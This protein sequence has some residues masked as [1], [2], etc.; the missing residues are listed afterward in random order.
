[1][2]LRGKWW[3]DVSKD[4]G[5]EINVRWGFL[6]DEGGKQAINYII[7][8]WPILGSRIGLFC[9]WDE[10]VHNLLLFGHWLR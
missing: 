2:S 1:M 4:V 9:L 6:F 7:V 5:L 3:G 10:C 8:V